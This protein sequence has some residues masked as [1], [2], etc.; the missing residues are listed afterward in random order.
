MYIARPFKARPTHRLD[1]HAVLGDPAGRAAPLAGLADCETD[2]AGFI[3]CLQSAEL[4]IWR[5]KV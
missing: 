2:I 4:D 3:P 1:R 5:A